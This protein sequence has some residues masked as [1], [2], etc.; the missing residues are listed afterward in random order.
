MAGGK[1]I[2]GLTADL[3]L[4]DAARHAL[5][6]RLELVRETLAPALYESDRDPE[7]V[8]QL[9]VATRRGRAALD[10]FSVCLPPKVCKRAR[11]ALREPAPCR[12]RGP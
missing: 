1:W 8:H 10:T 3:P 9:R 12:R 7:H 5:T 11:R 2:P 4:T 6:A